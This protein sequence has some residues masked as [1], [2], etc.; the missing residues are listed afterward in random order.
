[1]KYMKALGYGSSKMEY[2]IMTQVE[3]L[4][5]EMKNLADKRIPT[6]VQPMLM[7]AAYKTISDLAVGQ[8]FT[9]DDPRLPAF[10]KKVRKALGTFN[11]PYSFLA[12]SEISSW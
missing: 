4:L 2:I 1:M 3:D 9:P 7:K 12:L 10:L 11:N 6:F 8:V 5:D